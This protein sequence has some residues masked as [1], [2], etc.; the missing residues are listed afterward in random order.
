MKRFMPEKDVEYCERAKSDM[1]PCYKRD[2]YLALTNDGNCV[3][4]GI[5]PT[6]DNSPK[7]RENRNGAV[8][9]VKD[10]QDKA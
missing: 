7:P 6:D 10:A 8:Q 9:V 3:G 5:K 1:T 2:G 4:C